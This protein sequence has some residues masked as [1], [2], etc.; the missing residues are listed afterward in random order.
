MTRKYYEVHFIART[1]TAPCGHYHNVVANNL[2]EAILQVKKDLI[3]GCPFEVAD[4]EM[5]LIMARLTAV[6]LV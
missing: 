2:E 4:D 3:D 5:E 1:F 6:Q